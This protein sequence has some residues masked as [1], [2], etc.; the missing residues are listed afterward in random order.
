MPQHQTH[1]K[2]QLTLDEEQGQKNLKPSNDPKEQEIFLL[3][4]IQQEFQRVE[5]SK[6]QE[7]SLYQITQQT[8]EHRLTQIHTSMSET[9]FPTREVYMGINAVQAD[10]YRIENPTASQSHIYNI[11]YPRNQGN[12]LEFTNMTSQNNSRYSFPRT[13]RNNL[14]AQSLISGNAYKYQLDPY[15]VEPGQDQSIEVQLQG[16]Y[17]GQDQSATD[18]HFQTQSYFHDKIDGGHQVQGKI[19]ISQGQGRHAQHT[20]G[21]EFRSHQSPGQNQGHFKS[22]QYEGQ[23]HNLDS[24]QEY[25]SQKQVNH[26]VNQSYAYP[27]QNMNFSQANSSSNNYLYAEN[28]SV[29]RLTNQDMTYTTGNQSNVDFQEMTTLPSFFQLSTQLSRKTR[30]SGH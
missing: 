3:Q 28:M 12:N 13:A 30:L 10:I 2:D 22:F 17:Q 1:N 23:L 16:T 25:S 14:Q 19:D 6:G 24:V 20:Q 5:T 29:E 26:S 8:P 9:N 21:L 27:D 4:N 11:M 18:G 15:Q 7:P